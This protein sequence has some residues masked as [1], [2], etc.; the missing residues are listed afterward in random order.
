MFTWLTIDDGWHCEWWE[1]GELI[2]CRA[3][4]QLKLISGVSGVEMC[5][6]RSRVA[7]RLS[8]GRD[9]ARCS[10]SNMGAQCGHSVAGESWWSSVKQQSVEQCGVRVRAGRHE[11]VARPDPA[12]LLHKTAMLLH[13]DSCQ[14]PPLIGHMPR[15]SSLLIGPVMSTWCWT[16]LLARIHGMTSCCWTTWILSFWITCTTPSSTP[17]PHQQLHQLSCRPAST[18]ELCDMALQSPIA[19]PPAPAAVVSTEHWAAEKYFLSYLGHSDSQHDAQQYSIRW[20]SHV[21]FT[22]L[23]PMF[24]DKFLRERV[25]MVF[26]QVYSEIRNWDKIQQLLVSIRDEPN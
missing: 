5:V 23:S 8:V 14:S 22:I 18:S 2:H 13:H 17:T 6:P 15:Q 25:M 24:N 20:C 10:R 9:S 7:E 11:P 16:V 21:Y 19:W 4:S 3:G 12:R 1:R 26:K